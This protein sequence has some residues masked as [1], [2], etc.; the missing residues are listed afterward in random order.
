MSVAL[1]ALDLLAGLALIQWREPSLVMSQTPGLTR[2]QAFM[3]SLPAGVYN[4]DQWLENAL[5]LDDAGTG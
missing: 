5:Q 2:C 4:N 1:L 3:R